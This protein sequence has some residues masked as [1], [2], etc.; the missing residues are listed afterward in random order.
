MKTDK[1]LLKSFLKTLADVP[2]PQLAAADSFVSDRSL[3]KGEVFLRVGD[4]S[5]EFGFVASGLLRRFFIDADGN[6]HNNFFAREGQL[7]GSYESLR[8]GRPSQV[9][10]QAL[11]DSKL[12][13]MR[14]EDHKKLSD[15]YPEWKEAGFKIAEWIADYRARRESQ[16]LTQ[17]AAERYTDF[18]TRYPEL[19]ARIPQYHIASYLGITPE[20]L[21]RL[22]KNLSG[23]LK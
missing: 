21:S 9:G 6:E 4:V 18:S 19:A 22:V 12:L 23:R 1:D 20:A 11:E 14:F 3:R 7:I 5:H 17:S 13:V 10:I 16:L 2:D 15:K 8:S